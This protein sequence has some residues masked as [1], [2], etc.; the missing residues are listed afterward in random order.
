MA[1]NVP[2]GLVDVGIDP[3][4][5]DQ[6]IFPHAYFKWFEFVGE[7]VREYVTEAVLSNIRALV[8]YH[9]NPARVT[10]GT[11]VIVH[12]HGGF[13]PPPYHTIWGH[14]DNSQHR[15]GSAADVRPKEPNEMGLL[16]GAIAQTNPFKIGYYEG[17]IHVGIPGSD[18]RH[19][20]VS[21]SWW[22]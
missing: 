17:H 13:C 22:S 14:V 8:F 1:N 12:P 4:F 21:A 19:H 18:F 11:P 9:L 6:P 5:W 10:L 3:E 16:E 7:E 15:D 2:T 20:P